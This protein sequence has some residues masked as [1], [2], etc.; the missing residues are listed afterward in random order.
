MINFPLSTL[1][2]PPS[3]SDQPSTQHRFPA[4]LFW[5]CKHVSFRCS[6]LDGISLYSLTHWLGQWLLHTSR[7]YAHLN[8]R[9]ILL[10]LSFGTLLD[11]PDAA[12]YY[13]DCVLFTVW[14]LCLVLQNLISP[15]VDHSGL[16][17]PVLLEA[18]M[19]TFPCTS[20]IILMSWGLEHYNLTSHWI[21][22]WHL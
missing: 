20:F 18:Y 17:H 15:S 5:M 11:F 6:C 1:I 8:S 9:H 3:Y 14:L 13:Q 21:L 19:E 10:W 4:S 7:L 22:G 2:I 12:S 16:S